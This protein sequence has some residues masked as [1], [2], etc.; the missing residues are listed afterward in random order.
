MYSNISMGSS[1]LAFDAIV[2]KVQQSYIIKT[3]TKVPSQRQYT[4]PLPADQYIVVACSI[5]RKLNKQP[6]KFRNCRN[7]LMDTDRGIDAM[8]KAEN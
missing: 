4:V 1:G 3:F 6:Y 5:F 7:Y 2:E 8:Q